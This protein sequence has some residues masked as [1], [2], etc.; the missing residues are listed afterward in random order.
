MAKALLG[1]LVVLSV[2]CGG[3]PAS[4]S[5]V[6]P[7]AP[8]P[9]S[10][11][12]TP[13][14]PPAP[15]T[16][17]VLTG[18]V[19]ATNGGRA[20]EDLRV[21]FGGQSSLTDLTGAFRL[22]WP[23]ASPPG[24]AD[25]TLAGR[26]IVSRTA[27]ISVNSSR[28]VALDAIFSMDEFDLNYYRQ[29][30]RNGLE[31]PGTIRALRRWTRSPMIYLKTV[32]EGGQA[33]DSVTLDTVAGAIGN[34][35]GALTG[36][37]FGIAGIER[38]T[39]TREGQ[40]GWITVKWPNPVQTGVCG[41]AQIAVSGGWIELNYL[42]PNCACGSARVGSAVVRHEMGHALGFY[43]TDGGTGDMMFRTIR[44][45]SGSISQRERVHAAIAYSRPLGNTDP[46]TDPPGS[47]TL[48]PQPF[49]V[50]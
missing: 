22:E 37:R 25:I 21:T 13:P 38:G 15:P 48:R 36:E 39:G 23:A 50:D 49:V 6:T 41:R 27:R 47:E 11:T 40:A 46:D 42:N 8:A 5:R 24:T 1:A 28:T 29:L 34:D 35:T 17:I 9:A 12:P 31:E 3:E 44:T 14:P 7:P 18:R 30:V 33:V 20:L 10:P 19:T 2:A 45:C 4:P 16:T 43:H 26:Q 32:D